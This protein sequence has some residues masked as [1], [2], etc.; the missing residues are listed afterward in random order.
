MNDTDRLELR[1]SETAARLSELAAL[2]DLTAEQG[3]EMKRLTAS[4]GDIET[5]WQA[6][7]AAERLRTATAPPHPGG[8]TPTEEKAPDRELVELRSR[9]S[10]AKFVQAAVAQRSVTGAEAEYAAAVIPGAPD[11][12][13][14]LRLLE[15]RATDTSN[16]TGTGPDDASGS[17][18]RPVLNRIFNVPI[19]DHLG[20]SKE[21]VPAG[22]PV[23]PVAT[24]GSTPSQTAE[25]TEDATV[26]DLDLTIL[27]LEPRRLTSWMSFSGEFEQILPSIEEV[28]RRD[29][30]AAFSDEMERQILVGDGSAPN[31]SGITH[32]LAAATNPT[33]ASTYQEVSS[34]AYGAVDGRWAGMASDVKVVMPVAAYRYAGGLFETANTVDTALQML[35]RNSG[36][37]YA[38]A[39]L[40]AAGGGA[41]SNTSDCF[42]VRN[43]P[44]STWAV[45]PVW[46]SFQV[47]RDMYTRATHGETRL[48][49]TLY[50]NFD[51]LRSDAL[52][53][54][55]IR[56]A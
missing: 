35:M 50:W 24:A 25:G 17:T 52:T 21:M 26:D 39:H 11:G 43:R 7:A 19:T 45:C 28:L 56:R 47:V 4:V 20:I 13:I 38:S 34:L 37:V 10:L 33:A 32:G 15:T 2:D 42:A 46:D 36:G 48:I 23:W 8:L 14:P 22:Q 27:S 6:A 18:W 51:V 12:N 3:E 1:R 49:G 16:V 54:L 5:R 40:P 30:A 53:A 44:A 31:V 55:A 9:T 41:R 29:L